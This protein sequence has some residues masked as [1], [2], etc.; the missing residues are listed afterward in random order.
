VAAERIHR[1]DGPIL[2]QAYLFLAELRRLGLLQHPF[3]KPLP[4]LNFGRAP[5]NPV[6]H[7][8]DLR[9]DSIHPFGLVDENHNF[10]GFPLPP[11]PYP[12]QWY[13]FAAFWDRFIESSPAKTGVTSLSHLLINAICATSWISHVA[14]PHDAET[15]GIS[16]LGVEV[17]A[18]LSAVIGRLKVEYEGDIE[19]C[20]AEEP[21][22]SAGV[23]A[24]WVEQ[25]LIPFLDAMGMPQLEADRVLDQ[26]VKPV[27]ARFLEWKPATDRKGAAAGRSK[28]DQ[29]ASLKARIKSATSDLA[30]ES[31]L[32]RT[33]R[34]KA[35]FDAG[36]GTPTEQDFDSGPDP[37]PTLSG[38]GT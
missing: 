23:F 33:W 9:F 16:R 38:D 12:L 37:A 35:S 32:V 4:G 30:T 17:D 7:P 3:G 18:S 25:R 22:W 15:P 10:L 2:T 20:T 21:I 13:L 27:A 6:R 34:S 31:V 11:W 1:E 36:P 24:Y 29:W 5:L 19:K 14:A 8:H 26:A 28:D